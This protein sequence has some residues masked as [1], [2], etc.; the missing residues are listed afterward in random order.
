VQ[1][2][3]A[4]GFS[5]PAARKAELEAAEKTFLAIR[6]F[7][8]ETDEYRM[9]LGQVYYWLGRSSEGKELF[10]QLFAARKRPPT[11]LIA[12][13][14]KLREVGEQSQARELLEEAYKSGKDNKQKYA[15]AALRAHTSKDTDD[16][17]A[18]LERA[19]PSDNS[20]QIGLNNAR[21]EKALEQGNKDQAAQFIRKA[22]AGYENL[23]K[24]S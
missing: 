23:P 3:R 14:E 2:N 9:F 5:D 4:Q 6:G 16:K 12:L 11:L 8:G 13:A 24:N 19:D 20:T 18:W 10:D 21:G 22:I 7:A 17:I 15:A 1:V